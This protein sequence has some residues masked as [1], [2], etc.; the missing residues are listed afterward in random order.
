MEF[1]LRTLKSDDLFPMFG[2]LS[3]IGFKD[4]KE[5]ITPDKIKNMKS[6]ISQKDNE[7]EDENT[8]ATTML[9]V[10]VVMEVVSIIMKNLPS[11]KNEIYTFLSGLS[12]MTV[13]E[14]GNLDM[15]TFTEMIVAVVQKQEFKDFFKVVS[16]LFK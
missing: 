1:E 2:I 4:L 15:V 12:G 13:K 14:I 10:S 11:C 16:K 7:D 6:M 8:D 9:G 5:I 3:K